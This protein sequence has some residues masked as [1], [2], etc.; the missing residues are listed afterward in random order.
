MNYTIWI[1]TTLIGYHVWENI[2]LGILYKRMTPSRF[3]SEGVTPTVITLFVWI[4]LNAYLV[5]QIVEDYKLLGTIVVGFF[6]WAMALAGLF[7]NKEFSL[8]NAL[9]S[10]KG[11]TILIFTLT[12]C[13]VA[14][15]FLAKTDRINF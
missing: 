13:Y 8:Y 5:Y 6:G 7:G 4:I 10:K 2:L 11:E 12:I 15:L 9:K 3:S 1:I 14:T